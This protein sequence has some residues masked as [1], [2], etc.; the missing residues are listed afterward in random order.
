MKKLAIST[1]IMTAMIAGNAFAAQVK[2]DGEVASTCEISTQDVLAFGD[3]TQIQTQTI[4]F[5]VLCNDYDG[6]T[7]SL[8]STEGG[9]ESSDVEDKVI[10]YDATFTLGGE[11]FTLTT[12]VA[13]YGQND[14]TES[15]DYSSK[16]SLMAS[17]VKASLLA[18]TKEKAK[19]AG[20]YQDQLTV[21]ITAN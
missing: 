6:A 10:G 18:V 9:L 5:D 1:A 13:S 12:G 21:Q 7:I 8:I 2:L 3:L 14:K 20:Y 11:D 4:E 19:W 16:A 15:H 17:G